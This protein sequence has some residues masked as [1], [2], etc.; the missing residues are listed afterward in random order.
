MIHI[1]EHVSDLGTTEAHTLFEHAANHQLPFVL[2]GSQVGLLSDQES[3]GSQTG[4]LVAQITGDPEA[5]SYVARVWW[6]EL[7]IFSPNDLRDFARL[8]LNQERYPEQ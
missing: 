4:N 3:I 2:K 8:I 7:E 5:E 6:E 1:Y